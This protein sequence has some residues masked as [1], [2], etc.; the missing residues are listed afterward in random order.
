[1]TCNSW[2]IYEPGILTNRIKAA[3]DHKKTAVE[4]V[5]LIGTGRYNQDYSRDTFYCYTWLI[6]GTVSGLGFGIQDV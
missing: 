6:N 2:F 4:T 3:G 1:M 5:C